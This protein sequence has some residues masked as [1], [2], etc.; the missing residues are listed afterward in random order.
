MAKGF[1]SRNEFDKLKVLQYE[2]VPVSKGLDCPEC[3][4]SSDWDMSMPDPKPVG[5]CE[6]K[7]GFMMIAECPFCFTKFRY[8]IN[9]TGR[10]NLEEFFDD[11]ALR[12]FMY[13]RKNEVK[14]DSK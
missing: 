13:N 10:Y 5:W 6:T 4:R 3:H 9:T 7:Q 1:I 8:H 2:A 14:G 12:L 11:F